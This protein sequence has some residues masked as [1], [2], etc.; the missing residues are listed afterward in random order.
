MISILKNKRIVLGVSGSIACYKALD[1][2]SKLTQAGA[3][4]DVTLTAAAQRFVTPLAFRSLTGRPVYSNMWSEESHVQHVN[5]GEEADL[6]VIAPATAHTLAKLAHG[7]A[8]DIVS[9]TAL[10]L[11]APLLVAPAMDGGMYSHPATQANVTT[12]ANRSVIFCGPA[13]GRMASGLTGQ[14]RM[15]EPAAIVGDIRHQLGQQT[16]SLIGR[17]VVVT[18]GPTREQIDPVRFITNRSTGKQGVALAQAALDAG[19]EV[20][21]I[22]GPISTPAP[23]G[24]TVIP[25][26]STQ[27]MHDA[28][29][30]ACRNTDILLMAAAVADFRPATSSNQKIKKT[31][32]EAWGMAIALERTLDILEDVK[33]QRATSNSPKV[34]VGFAAETQNAFEYG[35]GKLIRKGLDLIAINDITA[36][37]AGFGVDTN[38]VLLINREEAVTDLPLMSKTAVAEQIMSMATGILAV[39]ESTL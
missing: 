28:T 7:M 37:G 38:H 26:T 18:A 2:A 20:T 35:R 23:Y 33:Q 27:E 30:E 16:G 5:L 9:L 3:L 22:A 32:A 10:S 12:L 34:V 17:H 19:A 8:D 1:L 31:Q 6:M 29:L 25:V 4:V 15:V 13:A 39:K 21:L 24:A 11:R 14:G 36:A